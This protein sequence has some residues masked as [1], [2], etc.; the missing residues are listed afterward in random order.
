MSS[1]RAKRHPTG[2]RKEELPT[3]PEERNYVLSVLVENRPGVLSRVAG[4]F[5]RRDFNIESLAVGKTENPDYS[6]MTIA[7]S[8]DDKTVEQVKKQLNTLIPVIKVTDLSEDES[9]DRELTLI[10]VSSTPET[11]NEIMQIAD[12]FRAKIVDV[13]K[14]SMVVEVTGDADKVEA[15]QD[16]LREFGIKEMVRTGTVSLARGE[17]STR[18]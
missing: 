1:E 4:L 17:K 12:T 7:V 8:G 2:V 15:L 5:T 18:G 6:R 14:T 10:K 3:E 9:V 16:M 11:R 13:G